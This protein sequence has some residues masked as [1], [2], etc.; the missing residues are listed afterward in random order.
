M[1]PSR[2]HG[3]LDYTSA[4]AL[5]AVPRLLG[6]DRRMTGVMDIAALGTATYAHL[7]DYELG[8][9]PLLSMR[10]H[11]AIDALEGVTFLSAAWMLEDEPPQVRWVLAGYGL[12]AL[13]AAALSDRSAAGHPRDRLSGGHR[14]AT[15]AW[16]MDGVEEENRKEGH[17]E[18]DMTDRRELGDRVRETE[19]RRARGPEFHRHIAEVGRDQNGVSDG[20]SAMAD[21]DWR[22]ARHGTGDGT[23]LNRAFV[24]AGGNAP[25]DREEIR[26]VRYGDARQS[27]LRGQGL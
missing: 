6:W 1:I 2:V 14:T 19:W 23:R 21:R 9:Y 20:R 5:A 7:T 10:H 25:G 17:W 4:F 13:A 8:A 22:Q 27:Y 16:I 11:L 18:D 12:F 24:G 26:R 3:I 15:G